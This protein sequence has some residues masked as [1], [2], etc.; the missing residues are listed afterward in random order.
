MRG[1]P[2]FKPKKGAQFAGMNFS[3]GA[4]GGSSPYTLPPATAS[5]LGGVKIGSGISVTSDGTISTSGGGY[6]IPADGSEFVADWTFGGRTVYGRRFTKTTS[7]Y[8][9]TLSTAGTDAKLSTAIKMDAFITDGT[10]KFFGNY[11]I[12]SSH[13][14]SVYFSGETTITIESSKLASY[15]LTIYYFKPTT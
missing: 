7:A 5:T 1:L 3:D 12:D 9:D 6:D 10:D 15:I 8:T 14:A 11:Y 2:F 4:G 13:Y